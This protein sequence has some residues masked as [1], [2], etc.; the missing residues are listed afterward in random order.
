MYTELISKLNPGIELYVYPYI[1]EA[2]NQQMWAQLSADGT[3]TVEG[4]FEFVGEWNAFLAEMGTGHRFTGIV[5]D[6]EEFYKGRNPTVE[7]E[8]N[9]IGPLKRKFGLKTGISFGYQSWAWMTQWDSVMDE[10]YLQFYD[11]YY[12]PLVD[13]TSD[14]PFLIYKNKPAALADFVL[15]TALEGLAE[16]KGKYGPKVHVMWSNQSLQG[17]CVYPMSDGTCGMNWEFGGW[18]AAAFNEYLR[19]F[20]LKS[21]NLGSMPQGIFQFSFVENNWFIRT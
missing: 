9:A 2:Y 7:A 4:V 6:Y 10:Y 8:M 5:V 13:R 19:Q 16:N 21:P 1:M 14:S 11:F 17:D 12:S 3:N 20:R 15:K 18:T